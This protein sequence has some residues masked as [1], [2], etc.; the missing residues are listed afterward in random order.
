MSSTMIVSRGRDRNA[1]PIPVSRKVTSGCRRHDNWDFDCPS[2]QRAA[3][4]EMAA[5]RRAESRTIASTRNN[6]YGV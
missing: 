2:C 3:G 6:R 1:T 4:I 5:I